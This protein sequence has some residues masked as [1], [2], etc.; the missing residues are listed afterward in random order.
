MNITT[1]IDGQGF[2]FEAGSLAIFVDNLFNFLQSNGPNL[3][4][5]D[6]KMMLQER[7]R[8]AFLIV[9][10]GLQLANYFCKFHKI[11]SLGKIFHVQESSALEIFR[12]RKTQN[13]HSKQI[14]EFE[15]EI[16]R[17]SRCWSKKTEIGGINYRTFSAIKVLA[18]VIS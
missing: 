3:L 1:S 6:S 17:N 2:E 7:I 11:D 18:F 4:P 14:V 16:I 8:F 12:H 15:S 5:K 13:T 9:R 10:H